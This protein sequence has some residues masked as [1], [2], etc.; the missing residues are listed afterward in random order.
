MS[1]F[2][3][4]QIGGL[5][6]TMRDTTLADMPEVLDLH[7]R[8]FGSAADPAWFAW[9]YDQGGGE[10]MGLW[11][12]GQ[13][14]AHCGGL[15]RQFLLGTNINL[16][17]HL[18][19]IGDVMVAPEWRGI[20]TRQGPFFH[21]SQGLYSTRLGRGNRFHAGFGF[22]NVRALRL[23]MKSGLTWDVGQMVV[24]QW[25]TPSAQPHRDG[26]SPSKLNWHVSP[27]DPENPAFDATLNHAWAAM[28]TGAQ[29]LWMG[30][31]TAAYVRWRFTQRPKHSSVFLQ[32]RRPWQRKAMGV[33]VMAPAS[34]EQPCMQWLDWIG[35]PN[36]MAVACAMC[37]TQAARAG[38]AGLT[39]WVSKAVLAQLDQTEISGQSEAARI[40]VAVASDMS[41]DEA[42]GLNW[43]FMGGD[44]DFL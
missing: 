22:P 41:Q 15:P 32:L 23:G 43:W 31:R 14:V 27:L 10:G 6:M 34:P 24:L 13:L 25:N 39:A 8:V 36:L 19:Q 37:R 1:V 5:P 4:L 20:L 29:T 35:P 33:A 30:E 16:A 17:K 38:T 11:H 42:I 28:Q 12:A 7:Q 26:L 21:V 40:S 44:T 18:L 9:K 3:L 2:E